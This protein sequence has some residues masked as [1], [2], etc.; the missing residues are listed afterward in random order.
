MSDGNAENVVLHRSA[1]S[2]RQG[3][4]CPGCK[5]P[6]P[7]R[8]KAH[9]EI[10][11]HWQ[12]AACGS[13]LTGLLVQDITPKMAEAVR[14]SQ[15]HFDTRDAAPVPESMRELLQEFI[16]LRQQNQTADERRA[17]PRIPQQ[18]DVTVVAVGEHWTPRGQPILGTVVDLTSHGLG[19]VTGALGG[20]GHVALQIRHPTG[21]LQ[22]LG[23]IAWT[24]D[25]GQ[26]FQDSGVQFLLRFGRTPV[27]VE[28]KSS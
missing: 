21:L 25:I 17:H 9:G 5:L 18:L 26:G 13:P 8:T 7:V 12:C 15:I 23:R 1:V 10:F 6:L 11:A 20:V 3:Q 27:T 4:P 24:K 2:G 28:P 22:L 16:A 14:I 19:M